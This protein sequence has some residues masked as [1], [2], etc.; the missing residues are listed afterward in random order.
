MIKHAAWVLV[1]LAMGCKDKA[2]AQRRDAP[3]PVATP[4]DAAPR[5]N[6]IPRDVVYVG[7]KG[8][9]IVRV[10]DGKATT[11]LAHDFTIADL[12]VDSHGIVYATSVSGTWRIEGDLVT[13]IPAVRSETSYAEHL[14]VGPD[15]VLWA[16]DDHGAYRYDGTA[17]TAFPESTFTGAELLYD[18][19]VDHENR[20]W[21]VTPDDLWRYDGATWQKLAKTFTRTKQPYFRTAAAGPDKVYVGSGAGVFAY[22]GDTWT[23]VPAKGKYD[24]LDGDELAVAPD[25][26][27]AMSGGVDDVAVAP[28][29]GAP[30]R[31]DLAKLGASARRAEV[32][33]VDGSGRTW[34]R[35]D[36]GIVI[37]DASGKLAAQWKPGTVEGIRGEVDAIAVFGNGP[38]L[39]TLVAAA[40]GT[41]VGKVLHEGKPVAAAAV[42][43]CPSPSMLVEKTPCAG[44]PVMRTATTGADGTFTIA[45]VPV[46]SYGVAVRPKR[47]WFVSWGNSDCC[48]AL[49]DG[50][51]FDLGALKL[52]KLE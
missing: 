26:R 8:T 38:T 23:K 48:T 21:V 51:T 10:V 28:S 18:I 19:A 16:L 4:V 52:D 20:V 41:V 35:T 33:A 39:P 12:V 17:W 50:G 29:G 15:G 25:G 27:L 7:V 31:I 42:E 2:P 13:P 34:L 1:L 43:L 3:V 47:T 45:D 44:A 32:A 22:A 24:D 5:P 37:L 36:G 30:V 49:E 9:G 14:A 11:V 6:V 46:G 40:H